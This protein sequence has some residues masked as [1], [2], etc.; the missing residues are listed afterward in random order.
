MLAEHRD[1][2]LI[3]VDSLTIE[4][5]KKTLLRAAQSLQQTI[6]EEGPL[7]VPLRRFMLAC[8]ANLYHQRVSEELFAKT[9]PVWQAIRNQEEPSHDSIFQLKEALESF[10]A[11]MSLDLRRF[12]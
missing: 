1:G 8:L 11:Q 7:E 6:S 2:G 5:E 9:A 4:L 10:I 12:E 3:E